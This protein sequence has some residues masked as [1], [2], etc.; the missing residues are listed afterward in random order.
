M[1]NIKDIELQFAADC[2]V[3]ELRYEYKGYTGDE[4]YGLITSLSEQELSCKYGCLLERYAPYIVLDLSFGEVRDD[5]RRNEHKHEVR[6][7]MG[8]QFEI[9]ED[10][11]EH[12]PELATPDSIDELIRK[13]ASSELWEAINKLKPLQKSRLIKHYFEGMSSREIAVAEGVN[14][15]AVDKSITTAVKNLK[16]FLS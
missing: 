9:S 15:S 7:L 12:H 13:E 6:L 10:F 3:I 4:R 1:A 8:N 16:Y 14:Y 11:E 2:K 5:F